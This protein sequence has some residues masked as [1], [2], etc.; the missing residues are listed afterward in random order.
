VAT[1]S[2]VL[3]VHVLLCCHLYRPT[4]SK[5]EPSYGPPRRAAWADAWGLVDYES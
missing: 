4:G 1:L 3:R 2:F 5:L